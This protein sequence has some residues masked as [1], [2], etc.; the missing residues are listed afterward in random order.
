MLWLFKPSCATKFFF[1]QPCDTNCFV[2]SGHHVTQNVLALQAI[3][4]QICLALQT[5]M[6]HIMFRLFRPSCDKKCLNSSRH[7]LTQMFR[8]FRPSCDMKC[9]ALQ[10]I[11]WLTPSRLFK[12]SCDIHPWTVGTSGHHVT[13]PIYRSYI[14][15]ALHAPSRF[16]SFDQ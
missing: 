2:S 5:I 1:R 4:W 15:I 13:H 8:I 9:L 6:W 3:I 11:V 10:A 16:F 14:F 7:H 12:L